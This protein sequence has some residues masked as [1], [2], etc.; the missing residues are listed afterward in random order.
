[1]SSTLFFSVTL[2]WEPVPCSYQ[3]GEIT[4]YV[5]KFWAQG[6]ESSHS[7]RNVIGST[8]LTL[9]NLMSSTSYVCQVAAAN[10]AGT[11]VFSEPLTA[12]TGT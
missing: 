9:S 11:G 1:M 7:T 10:S 3:N 6:N 4:G 8:S 12:E 5:V 2:L